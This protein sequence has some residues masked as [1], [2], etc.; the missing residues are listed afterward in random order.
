MMRIIP[1]SPA[2]PLYLAATALAGGYLALANPG[3]LTDVSARLAPIIVFVAGMSIVVNI[4]SKAG[5]FDAL[6]RCMEMIAR[7]EWSLWA[8]F[9]A[10]SVFTTVFSSLDTTAI[11]LT[12]MAVALA[13]RPWACLATLLW[14]DQLRRN[15]V[16][17]PWADYI[18][19]GLVLTPFA[20]GVPMAAAITF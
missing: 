18:K 8:A 4:A 14:H 9:M 17:L 2:I 6:A 10:L 16:E 20:V 5:A 1:K 11:M 19:R 13:R 15:S 3:E 12:P 7:N